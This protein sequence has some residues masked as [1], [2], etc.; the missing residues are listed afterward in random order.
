MSSILWCLWCWVKFVFINLCV[1][2]LIFCCCVVFRAIIICDSHAM[3]HRAIEIAKCCVAVESV[4]SICILC[5]IMENRGDWIYIVVFFLLCTNSAHFIYVFAELE[6]LYLWVIEIVIQSSARS[7]SYILRLCYNIYIC[8]CV[9][10]Y[11]IHM[12]ANLYTHMFSLM[13]IF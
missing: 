11:L 2:Y 13:Y 3:W 12:C 4:G 6:L 8:R 7:L 10:V 5:C 1:I 9:C